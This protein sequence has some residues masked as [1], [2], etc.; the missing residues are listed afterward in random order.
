[1]VSERFSLFVSPLNFRTNVR[2]PPHVGDGR[3]GNWL[4]N[5][6]DWNVSRNRYWGTPIPLWVSDDFEE[7]SP[8]LLTGIRAVADDMSRSCAS[9]QWKSS[10]SCLV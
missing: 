7:V 8:Q 1:M 6:R 4:V 10:R 3:F 2:V 5:A 9:V